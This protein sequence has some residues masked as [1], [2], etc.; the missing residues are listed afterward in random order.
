MLDKTD[1]SRSDGVSWHSWAAGC[2][3][4]YC[5]SLVLNSSC[6]IGSSEQNKHCPRI[7]TAAS[8]HNTCTCVNNCW[9]W[10]QQA[11]ART[12]RVVQVVSTGNSRIDALRVL[13]TASNSCHCITRTYLIQPSLMSVGIPNK[14]MP[15]S[16]SSHT[17]VSGEKKVAVTSDWRKYSILFHLI[18][19]SYAH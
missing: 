7:V 3:L 19:C 6:T 17:K 5:V 2:V 11:N 4:Q 1:N 9:W 14:Q 15:P 10:C 13:L 18:F 12:V 8:I 16:N